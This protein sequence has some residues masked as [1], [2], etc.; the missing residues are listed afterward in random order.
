MARFARKRERIAMETIGAY[1]LAC[2][3]FTFGYL[4]HWLINRTP[5]EPDIIDHFYVLAGDGEII[6]CDE[7]QFAALLVGPKPSGRRV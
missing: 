7:R 6:K 5:P 1:F 2:G 3:A 4:T